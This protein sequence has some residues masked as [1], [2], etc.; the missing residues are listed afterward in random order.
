M[1]ILPLIPIFFGTPCIY[2]QKK[3]NCSLTVPCLSHEYT[4]L[5]TI[6]IIAGEAPRPD[7]PGDAVIRGEDG[8]P[9]AQWML[10]G[11]TE[12][13]PIIITSRIRT[14]IEEV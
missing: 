14:V 6:I 8:R 7:S 11:E 1:G 10:R 12:P 13:E 4:S 2:F 3:R 9:V 5:L